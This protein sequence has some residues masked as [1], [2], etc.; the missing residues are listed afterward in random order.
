[1]TTA[2]INLD[3][4]TLVKFHHCRATVLQCLSFTVKLLLSD[5]DNSKYGN[6][7]RFDCAFV[8]IF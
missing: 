1:M 2:A 7:N 3:V 5:N 4:S 8:Y 6:E